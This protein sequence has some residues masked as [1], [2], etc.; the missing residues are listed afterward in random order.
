ME[1]L[2]N[3]KGIFIAIFIAII[4]VLLICFKTLGGNNDAKWQEQYDLGI[5][6]LE[7]ENYEDAIVA[8]SE[9]IKIDPNRTPA[10]IGRGDAY[11]LSGET[12]E[13]LEL[14]LVDYQQVLNLDDTVPGAYLGIADVYIRQ[15]DY[16]KALEILKDG[17]EKTNQN[18]EIAAKIAEI[19]S[20]PTLTPS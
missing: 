4:A 12:E 5:R 16:D 15:G 8:F 14:A 17:L 9:A 1:Q 7:E 11:I 13:H 19:E 20:G 10:Y 18:E 2:K 6:Y 3:R